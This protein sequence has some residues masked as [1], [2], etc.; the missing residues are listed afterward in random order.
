VSKPE[1]FLALGGIAVVASA[2]LLVTYVTHSN[3]DSQPDSCS[4]PQARLDQTLDQVRFATSAQRAVAS[5]LA[6]SDRSRHTYY[7]DIDS[8]HGELANAPPA[9]RKDLVQASVILSDQEQPIDQAQA[10]TAE[11]KQELSSGVSLVSQASVDL[12][13]GDCTALSLTMA[14]SGWPKEHLLDQLAL[15]AHLNSTVSD[16]LDTALALIVAAQQAGRTR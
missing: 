3:A 8:M 12:H 4:A 2:I 1:R 5:A 15:A 10:I 11:A 16:H 9:V 13:N 14:R 7:E 6:Y